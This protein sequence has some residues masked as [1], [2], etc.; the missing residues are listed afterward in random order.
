MIANATDYLLSKEKDPE[1]IYDLRK[2]K[3]NT[4]AIIERWAQRWLRPRLT[5]EDILEQI[6]K[7]NLIYPITHDAKVVLPKFDID[8]TTLDLF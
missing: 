2:I 4:T 7:Q 3:K 8:Q 6:A 1:Y 5:R